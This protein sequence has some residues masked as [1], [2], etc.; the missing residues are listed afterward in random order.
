MIYVYMRISEIVLLIFAAITVFVIAFALETFLPKD[1]IPI[2]KNETVL[3]PLSNPCSRLEQCQG[4]SGENL[5]DCCF[6]YARSRRDHTLCEY[7]RTA[8]D[9]CFSTIGVLT[10]NHFLCLAAG[11]AK[12]VCLNAVAEKTLNAS[13]CL[14]IENEA[15]KCISHVSVLAQDESLCPLAEDLIDE[16]Y[17]GVAFESRNSDVCPQTGEFKDNCYANIGI[18]IGDIDLCKLAGLLEE[19]CRIEILEPTLEI[20]KP[21]SE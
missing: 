17:Y 14:K 3:P 5:D 8:Q 16:C 9:A 6:G 10:L 4:F 1:V 2:E 7:T 12:D 20:I 21:A 15:F 19:G 11:S 13:L 18:A